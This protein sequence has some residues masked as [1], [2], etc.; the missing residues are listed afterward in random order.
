LSLGTP[1]PKKGVALNAK[2]LTRR[3]T[4]INGQ[5][6]MQRVPSQQSEV[7]PPHRHLRP[8]KRKVLLSVNADSQASLI[9]PKD[10]PVGERVSQTLSRR[11]TQM[12][13]DASQSSLSGEFQEPEISFA[14]R[15]RIF[16][17]GE[18]T[19]AKYGRKMSD[20]MMAAPAATEEVLDN[21]MQYAQKAKEELETY[22]RS[23]GLIKI[24]NDQV[25]MTRNMTRGS[26]AASPTGSADM[27]REKRFSQKTKP[28][29]PQAQ[30][31][32]DLM[33]LG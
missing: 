29:T 27:A 6:K 22:M 30:T 28:V 5:L 14:E 25:T 9:P 12:D 4:D 23:Q 21:S 24:S 32:N 26:A 16:H 17:E 2:V 18:F 1:H 7:S 13:Y 11:L 20:V 8:K 33:Y 19:I 31:Q 15:R 3:L 10:S